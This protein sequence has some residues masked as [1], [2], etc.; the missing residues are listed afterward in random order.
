MS[1]C[2]NRIRSCSISSTEVSNLRVSEC[3]PFAT[4]RNIRLPRFSLSRDCVRVTNEKKTARTRIRRDPIKMREFTARF[5]MLIFLF[6]IEY[7]RSDYQVGP[8]NIESLS[9]IIRT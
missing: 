1:P 6:Y 7:S 4:S 9:A 3:P 2:S 5:S 8:R